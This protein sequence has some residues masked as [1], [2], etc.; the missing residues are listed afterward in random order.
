M[1]PEGVFLDKYEGL[2]VKVKKLNTKNF[3][4][5]LNQIRVYIRSESPDII[6]AHG[7]RAAFWGRL[8]LGSGSK[9]SR[10]VYTLHGLHI[11][12]KG[13]PV[14]HILKLIERFLNCKTD[15][16]CCV[17][18]SD[19]NLVIKNRLM[20]P[21]RISVL[22]NGID[23]SSFQ[24]SFKRIEEQK[25]KLNLLNDKLLVS[26]GRLHEQKDFFTVIAAL[27]HVIAKFENVKLLIVGDG[28]LRKELEL[29]AHNLGLEDN[30]IFMGFKEDTPLFINMADIV[31]LSSFWEGLPLV[32][33]ETAAA[34]KAIVASDRLH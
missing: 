14:R 16:L 30:V 3:F 11:I 15:V 9:K 28:V 8:A 10:F 22:Q 25:K 27:K 19:K 12:R 13:F 23:I 4:S 34:K 7:T 18:K 24:V 21:E 17:S 29:Q 31:V 33:L 20:K 2:G 6:H 1:A 26:I 32:P 5:T